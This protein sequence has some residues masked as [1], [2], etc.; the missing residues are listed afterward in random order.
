MDVVVGLGRRK[1]M[2]H[3]L[4]VDD[5]DAERLAHVAGGCVDLRGHMWDTCTVKKS[6]QIRR[7]CQQQQH[8]I[9]TWHNHKA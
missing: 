9:T 1:P 3:G 6:Q 2:T 8:G 5:G 7:S 4:Q